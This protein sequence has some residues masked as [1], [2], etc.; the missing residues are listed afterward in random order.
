MTTDE[1]NGTAKQHS[2][3]EEGDGAGPLAEELTF[4][5]GDERCAATL[6]RPREVG[7]S[8]A[9]VVLAQGFSLTRR[10]GV[11]RYADAFARAGVAALTFDYR[12]FGDSTG[13]PRQLTDHVLQREDLA[14]AIELARSLDAVDPERVAVWGYSFGGGH[15]LHLAAEDARLAGVILHFPMVD[16]LATARFLGLAHGLR[17]TGASL[18]AL[19]GRRLARLP[20]TGPP[21]SLA[22]LTRPEAEPGFASV[23]APGSGW[24]N[25]CRVR[26]SQP[27]AGYRPVRLARG[28]QA[29]LLACLGESDTIVP[30]APIVRAAAQAPNGRLRRYALAHFDPFTDGA[31]QVLADQVAF[32][33]RHVGD[34]AAV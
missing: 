15:A 9:C 16:G 6:Y 22:M 2:R 11:P 5:S 27:L 34:G 18:R 7:V 28:V 4:P 14:A 10:D 30:P 1:R 8:R 32:L 25:E 12:H 3:A 24:R 13:Q 20:V 26:P 33:A 31:P 21:G 19:F 29:P 17:V 23:R